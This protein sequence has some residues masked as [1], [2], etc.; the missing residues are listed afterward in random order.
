[1]YHGVHLMQL[2]M[3]IFGKIHRL[4]WHTRLLAFFISIIMYLFRSHVSVHAIFKHKKNELKC[5]QQ[6]FYEVEFSMSLS[7]WLNQLTACR[8][9]TQ[10]LYGFFLLRRWTGTPWHT[11]VCT[12]CI[13]F[14]L[15][16]STRCW[17]VAQWLLCADCYIHVI[18]LHILDWWPHSVQLYLFSTGCHV[19]INAGHNT[20]L[21]VK[22]LHCCGM[23]PHNFEEYCK[24]PSIMPQ[25][26]A[27][28][29]LILTALYYMP[30]LFY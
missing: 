11:E 14:D 12:M 22:I 30:W 1:V 23:M 7:E 8:K 13:S 17:F 29:T 19:K 10:R 27:H 2:Y 26:C 6:I 9:K 3:F 28:Y 5:S 21:A 4:Q 16:C 25:N 24:V 18:Y 20:M 15:L